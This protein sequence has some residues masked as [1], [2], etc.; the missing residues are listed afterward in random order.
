MNSSIC[1][2]FLSRS[3][4]IHAAE[5]VRITLHA[6]QTRESEGLQQQQ[7]QKS[8]R[9]LGIVV[10]LLQVWKHGQATYLAKK[11]SSNWAKELPQPQGLCPSH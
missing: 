2:H 3:R 10:S 9:R 8:H 7:Q 11:L 1:H 4:V 5:L 6:Q